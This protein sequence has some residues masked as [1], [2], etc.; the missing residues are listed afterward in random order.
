MSPLAIT[1][2]ELK[3]SQREL[4]RRTGLAYQTVTDAYHGRAPVSLETAVKMAKALHVPVYRISP[5][6]AEE[7]AGV[8]LR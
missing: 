2:D 4:C 5:I 7:L 3:V 6:A 1:L 8:A